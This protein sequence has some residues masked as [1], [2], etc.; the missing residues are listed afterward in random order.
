MKTRAIAKLLAPA[1]FR[2]RQKGV[3]IVTVLAVLVLMSVLVVSFF[4]MSRTEQIS[5]KGGA[6]MNRNIALR[7]LA[8]NTV[9][10]RLRLATTEGKVQGQDKGGKTIWVSQPGAITTF[11][12]D[13]S[14]HN[15]DSSLIYKLYSCRNPITGADAPN[16][17]TQDLER[18]WKSRPNIFVDLNRPV[19]KPSL[20]PAKVSDQKAYTAHYPICHPEAYTA[21]ATSENPEGFKYTTRTA[22]PN[23]V[24]VGGIEIGKTL[25]MPVMWLYV[26]QDG[27]LL[28][29]TPGSGSG[30]EEVTFIP[31]E[32]RHPTA[33]NPIVGRVAYWTD[34]ESC[35][36]NINTASEGVFWDTP[37]CDSS[38]ERY[39]AKHQPPS[40]EYY[41]FPGHPAQTCLSSV[42]FPNKRYTPAALD[43]SP[44]R[45][46]KA[47]TRQEVELLW[48]V[49]PFVSLISTGN[50]GSNGGESTV[51]PSQ[52]R[53]RLD[54]SQDS[55]WL[56]TSV[57]ELVFSTTGTAGNGVRKQVS[58][59]ANFDAFLRRLER[60]QFFLTAKSAAPEINLAGHPRLSMWPVNL[61][62]KSAGWDR[63]AK[64]TL[65]D[66][67][68]SF[69]SRFSSGGR[70][71]IYHLQRVDPNSR[72]AELYATDGRIRNLQML[73]YLRAITTEIVPGFPY[74]KSF[75]QK[76]AAPPK[77]GNDNYSDRDQVLM[78]MV[79]YVRSVNM[80][81]PSVTDPYADGA[82][83]N[84]GIGQHAAFCLCGGSTPHTQLWSIRQVQLPKGQGRIFGLSEIGFWFGAVGRMNGTT[85]EGET[86]FSS[87]VPN[88]KPPPGSVLVQWA[89]L[90]E[91]FCAG[92]GWSWIRPKMAVGIGS[93]LTPTYNAFTSPINLMG[94]PLE[95]LNQFAQNPGVFP[96]NWR[97]WGG[98]GGYRILGS[99]V[100]ATAVAS[101]KPFWVPPGTG[102]LSVPAS[103]QG[104]PLRITVYDDSG[105]GVGN[106][107]QVYYLKWPAFD[108][109]IPG[110][111][112][113]SLNKRMQASFVN[114]VTMFTEGTDTILSLQPGNPD[115]R[116][117]TGPRA[118]DMD[119]FLPHPDFKSGKAMAHSLFE[120]GKA[121]PPGAT[122]DVPFLD[123]G[124]LN[125]QMPIDFRSEG[126][127]FTPDK[128]EYSVARLDQL[129][130]GAC[131]PKYTGDF[132]NGVADQ[133]DGPYAGKVDEGD[134]RASVQSGVPY[135]DEQIVSSATP[136]IPNGQGKNYSVPNRIV[137]GPGMFGSISTGLQNRVPFQTLLLRPSLY[138]EGSNKDKMHYGTGKIVNGVYNDSVEAQY[139]PDHLLLDLFWM[140]V[141]EPYAISDPMATKGKI[142]LNY[143]IQPFS[144]IT[145]STG[146][147]GLMKAE[148]ML[149]I[150]TAAAADYKK[151]TGGA[152]G[153]K[154]NWRHFINVEE[155]LRQ[156]ED[157]AFGKWSSVKPSD[158][159]FR[160]AS[161]ICGLHL[162]PDSDENN[163]PIFFS[164][165]NME[166]F[167]TN[168][169]LTGDNSREAP[170][171]HLYPRLTVRSNV[172]KIHYIVQTIQKSKGADPA[173]FDPVKDTVTVEYRGSA[174][175]ER[176]IDAAD[177]VLASESLDFIVKPTQARSLDAFYSYRIIEVKQFAP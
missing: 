130:R 106:L 39:Y 24:E 57:D 157:P 177:P 10:G 102:T 11:Y 47:M 123:L 89:I 171:A 90:P 54:S 84:T 30:D 67:L 167:W 45:A 98:Y 86:D 71:N 96:K 168:H 172:F 62:V 165:K 129:M 92:H 16:A 28:Q 33:E 1:R 140:P 116:L 56:Y 32:G 7:D 79:D 75:R 31:D 27:T 159:L 139:P 69:N 51:P 91:A 153:V 121:T 82:G 37:R 105:A 15:G 154:K 70:S 144:Y 114:D 18:D 78:E 76:Y 43:A 41:R 160:S 111:K 158:R 126:G 150:P 131:D 166:T 103:N 110:F 164:K 61:S 147:H 122:D 63:G 17:F 118:I 48:D 162:V 124:S 145:R 99:N 112:G 100:A 68:I 142:N 125:G 20:D 113:I 137:S 42:L 133:P 21:G 109:R 44:G 152:N 85:Y 52:T 170:Y 163:A 87:Y 38:E 108:V 155:T 169:L 35:K 176:S 148:R 88:P 107:I 46:M 143:Q 59:G 83:T 72:H 93:G 40:L 119:L 134:L 135:F 12:A 13:T 161:E 174:T 77:Y 53:P 49:A 66:E 146:M 34:D 80:T 23:S 74:K 9:I 173:V 104:N 115:Y 73:D 97:P 101:F 65:Q 36:I 5:A 8:I 3:A 149:A 29:P 132:E 151:A 14:G 4:G 95:L 136:L 58:S 64:A 156:I 6:E 117:V 141:V 127:V 19:F 60:S 81:D 50:G 175:V 94:K 55:D 2:Y 128:P 22:P 26:L 120:P 138:E 25:P